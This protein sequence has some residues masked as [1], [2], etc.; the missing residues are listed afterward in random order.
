MYKVAS[1]LT[2]RTWLWNISVDQ[3]QKIWRLTYIQ[4]LLKLDP[5]R[6]IIHVGT[7]DLRSSQDPETITK[8][9]IDIA[10]NSTTNKNEI[11]VSSI[12]PLPDNVNG[13]G[14]QVN[15]ILQK[16]CVENNFAYVNHENIKSRQHCNYGGVH[17]NTAGSKIL[18]ENFILA[19]SRQT[20]LGIIRDNDALIGN[21]SETESNSETT[22]YLPEDSLESKSDNH[23]NDENISFPF[24]K[25]IRSKHPKNL[26]FGQ[27]N[28]NS[29]RNKFESV[30]EIIQNTFDI[31]LVCETKTYTFFP[32][33]QF[34]IPEYSI[35]RKDRNARG[36]GLFFYVNQDLNCKVLNKYPTRHDVEIL[37]LELKLSKTNG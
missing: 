19:L 2:E 25:K 22:K 12:V 27:L 36:G 5:D 3:Q 21:V 28:V 32:N 6:L 8:N 23:E 16:L 14:R 29:I 15:N 24:L 11:L 17:L 4:A 31:F 7:N 1:Y 10:K 33:Q 18:A 34:C 37:V 26:F 30:Q 35:F 20:W 9:I 13:K